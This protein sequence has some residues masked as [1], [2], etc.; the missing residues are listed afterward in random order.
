MN[1]LS[2]SVDLALELQ[3]RGFHRSPNCDT[4]WFVP[5]AGYAGPVFPLE[6]HLEADAIWLKTEAYGGR[7][8]LI[9]LMCFET[10][11]FLEGYLKNNGRSSDSKEPGWN[12]W[13]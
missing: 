7:G 9:P 4:Q 13:D 5:H 12:V 10:V 6:L 2:R 11:D 8:P 3:G 1:T